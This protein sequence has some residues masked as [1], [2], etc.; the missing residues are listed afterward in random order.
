MIAVKRWKC[1]TSSPPNADSIAV[2]FFV[3]LVLCLYL[4]PATF[5]SKIRALL[6]DS[7]NALK[8]KKNIDGNWRTTS[9]DK[10]GKEVFSIR[11]VM[12]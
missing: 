7:L 5:M 8:K 12:V 10:N 2:V 9:K 3:T 6:Q 11:K 1:W 4:L